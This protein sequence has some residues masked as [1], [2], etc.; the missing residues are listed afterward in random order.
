MEGSGSRDNEG[1]LSRGSDGRERTG[2][3]GIV[4]K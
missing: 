4:G 2:K 1:R 3:C